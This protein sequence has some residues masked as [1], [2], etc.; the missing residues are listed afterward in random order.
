MDKAALGQVFP[1]TSVCPVKHSIECST[2]IIIHHQGLI[3]QASNDL[4]STPLR[5][6]KKKTKG[7]HQIGNAEMQSG[8]VCVLTL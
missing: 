5:K 1:S 7:L 8:T 6:R 4:G 3:Q 2:L